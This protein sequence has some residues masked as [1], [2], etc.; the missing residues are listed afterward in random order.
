MI[1]PPYLQVLHFGFEVFA[2]KLNPFTASD[3]KKM[4]PGP[5]ITAIAHISNAA[6]QVSAFI[7]SVSL[8]GEAISF[9]SSF[10]PRNNFTP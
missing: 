6:I 3:V 8:T 9:S 10:F 2:H 4:K 7:R 1:D 5:R